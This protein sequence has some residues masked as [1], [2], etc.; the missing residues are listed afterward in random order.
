MMRFKWSVSGFLWSIMQLYHS[1]GRKFRINNSKDV[2]LTMREK[3]LIS[4]DLFNVATSPLLLP[5]SFFTFFFLF[6]AFSFA[7]SLSLSFS[8]FYFLLFSSIFPREPC[9]CLPPPALT[10]LLLRTP[11]SL[12]HSLDLMQISS[13]QITKSN[14]SLYTR[15]KNNSFN[16]LRLHFPFVYFVCDSLGCWECVAVNS[17]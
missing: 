3:L 15:Y 13:E 10:S 16:C 8:P 14:F 9:L 4:M 7:S 5:L 1:I 6:T 12:W 2:V 17:R 11:S